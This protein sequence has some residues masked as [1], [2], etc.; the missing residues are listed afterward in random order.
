M[1]V[2]QPIVHDDH[3]HDEDASPRGQDLVLSPGEAAEFDT[4]VPH[5]FGA[6]GAEGVE[7]LSLFGRQGERAHL[8]ARPRGGQGRRDHPTSS[9]RRRQPTMRRAMPG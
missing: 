2:T 7:F 8:R 3:L 1:A 6:A 4:R 9:P 5:W